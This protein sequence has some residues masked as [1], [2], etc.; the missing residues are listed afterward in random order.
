MIDRPYD[1]E[2][3]E[4]IKLLVSSIATSVK[5]GDK[6]SEHINKEID[7]L[8]STIDMLVDM[9]NDKDNESVSQAAEPSFDTALG[10][11][12]EDEDDETYTQEEARY[13]FLSSGKWPD[14]IG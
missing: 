6:I 8:V 2:K 14:D 13:A 9:V 5:S 1:P 10:Y 11:D 7:R 3:V 4:G 12:D